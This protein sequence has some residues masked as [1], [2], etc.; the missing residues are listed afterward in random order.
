MV[1]DGPLCPALLY[2]LNTLVCTRLAGLVFKETLK[3]ENKYNFFS[4]KKSITLNYIY[5]FKNL[6]KSLTN[7]QLQKF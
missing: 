4:L 3:F 2:E 6:N 7:T 5:I 1:T